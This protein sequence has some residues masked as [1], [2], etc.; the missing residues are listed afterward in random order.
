MRRFAPQAIFCLLSTAYCLLPTAYC[1][2]QEI[3]T[4]PKWTCI[5][6]LAGDNFL[7][8]FTQ[9]NLEELREGHGTASY[10]VRTVVLVDKLDKGGHLY[11]VRNG[12]LLELPVE[13][14][15]PSWRGK[16]LNTGAPQTLIT[17]ATW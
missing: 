12:Y 11:E 16:E 4:L 9:Q 7:D 2:G 13:D 14:I 8:W 3:K 17:F 15:D 5:V 10:D 6:Y 1:H